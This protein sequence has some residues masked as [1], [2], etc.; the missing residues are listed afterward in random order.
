MVS[1]LREAS[2]KIIDH[3]PLHTLTA[4]VIILSLLLIPLRSIILNFLPIYV[5]RPDHFLANT[6]FRHFYKPNA[7]VPLVELELSNNFAEILARGSQ[8][9]SS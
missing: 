3:L 9:V 5:G 7:P 2:L 1:M 6:W 8:L 4:T